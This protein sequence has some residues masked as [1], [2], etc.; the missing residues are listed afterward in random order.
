MMKNVTALVKTFLRDAYLFRAVE[1][2]KKLHPDIHII[3]ADDGHVSHAKES[4]LKEMGVERYIRL[5]YASCGIA[6]GRNLLVGVCQTKYC[7]IGDDDFLYTP[8]SRLERLL[9]LMDVADNAGGAVMRGGIL[10]H[11]EDFYRRIPE[12]VNFEDIDSSGAFGTVR[13]TSPSTSLS[14]KPQ[15]SNVSGGMSSFTPV[16]STRTSS[17]PLTELG[18]RPCTVLTVL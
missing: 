16:G 13:R 14:P 12:G 18:S 11:F 10:D 17:S 15:H 2:L 9:K 6:R 1:S 5:P 8:D 4:K 3:V 7:L